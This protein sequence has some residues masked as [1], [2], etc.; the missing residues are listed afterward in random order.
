MDALCICMCAVVELSFC[1]QRSL[2]SPQPQFLKK[3]ALDG[4]N[5]AK[6][7]KNIKSPIALKLTS[8]VASWV[9]LVSIKVNFVGSNITECAN[10]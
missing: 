2:A 6:P 8:P 5:L 1:K 3:L 10:S 4:A 7:H 9:V